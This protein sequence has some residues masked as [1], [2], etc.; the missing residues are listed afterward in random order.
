MNKELK[1]KISV[2]KKTG[3]VKVI[4]GEFDKL[5]NKAGKA[6]RKV[7][8]FNK[9]LNEVDGDLKSLA[10]MAGSFYVISQAISGAT[11]LMS[12]YLESADKMTTLN[13]KLRLVTSSSQELQETQEKLF[14]IAQNT[15]TSLFSNVDL[16]Q[17]I[18]ASTRELN[19]SQKERLGLVENINKAMVI[20]G[21][22]TAGVNT[23][24][25]QLG[26]AF[27]SDFKSVAQDLRSVKDQAFEL[28]E[29]FLRGTKMNA[30]EFRKAAQDGELSTK[31]MIDAI[32]SQ[33]T[34]VDTNFLK[35]ALTVD[36]ASQT[37][38]NSTY[39]LIENMDKITGIS[40]SL[41]SSI[42]GFRKSLD[43]L[44]ED[45]I[46]GYADLAGTIGLVGTSLL[47]A[48]VA[49]KAYSTLLSIVASITARNTT[50]LA[51]R[52]AI[53]TA[54][55]K[56]MQLG[57]YAQNARTLADNASTLAIKNNSVV[58]SIRAGVL[59]EEA[60]VAT[61]AALAQT[62][63]ARA[64]DASTGAASR[65]TIV[66]RGLSLVLKS[67]PFIG[68]AS[69]VFMLTNYL[70]DASSASEDLAASLDKTGKKL[71]EMSKN[72]LEH[73]RTVI[74]SSLAD[75]VATI[76]ETKMDA[77]YKSWHETAEEHA[78]DQVRKDEALAKLKEMGLRYKNI[79]QMIKDIANIQESSSAQAKPK[80]IDKDQLSLTQQLNAAI[81]KSNPY[82]DLSYKFEAY[83]LKAK[84]NIKNL[85][86]I[87]QWYAMNFKKLKD[88]ELEVHKRDLL[89]KEKASLDV[90]TTSI[91]SW[92]EYYEN[93][94]DY[95]TSWLIQES[96]FKTK[97][98]DLTDEQFTQA[99]LKA[100]EKYFD[101]IGKEELTLKLNGVDEAYDGMNTILDSQLALVEST[102]SW[103]SNLSGVAGAFVDIS[104]SASKFR[105]DEINSTKNQNNLDQK[106]AKDYL[107]LE[108]K[109]GDLK[110]LEKQYDID[111]ARLKSD[112]FNN[113]IQGYSNIA[114]A[115]GSMYEEG[116]KGAEIANMAQGI[117]A[118]TQGA[119]AI[120]T[121]GTG[122]PYTAI[123][124]MIAMAATV[125][126]VLGNA[127]IS[128][129]EGIS[130]GA[131]A[132]AQVQQE[133]DTLEMSYEPMTNRLD[134]QIE[135]LESIDRN[136]SAAAL[137]VELAEVEF[138]QAYEK[139]K[140]ETFQKARL[141]ALDSYI[142]KDGEKD[143]S[144][145]EERI[146]VD[147]FTFG[148]TD[149]QQT[150][151]INTEILKEK[152]NLAIALSDIL[153]TGRYSGGFEQGIYKDVGFGKEAHTAFRLNIDKSFSDLQGYVNDW[154][155]STIDSVNQLSDASSTLKD[156][157]DLIG[158]GDFSYQDERLKE[159]FIDLD[160]LSDKKGYAQYIK[161]EIE[162]IEIAKNYLDD[163]KLSLLLSKDTK[164]FVAQLEVVTEFSKI[165]G[166]AFTD[167]AK[168]VINYIE[169]IE[170]V[171]QAMATSEKN[172][173]SW[174]DSFKTENEITQDLFKQSREKMATDY[175]ELQNL[176]MKLSSD[177]QG[178]DDNELNFLNANKSFLDKEKAQKE[179]AQK[180]AMDAQKKAQKEA[181]DAHKKAQ[182]EK[183]DA[184]KKAYNAQIKD[185][186]AQQ[187]ALSQ[188]LSNTSNSISTIESAMD[189]LTGVI[190][191]LS[192][193]TKGSSYHIDN[194]FSSMQE[195]LS[196]SRTK[197]RKSFAESLSKTI[198]YSS[199]LFKDSNFKSAYASEFERESALNEFN[200]M[201]LALDTELSV[202][203]QIEVNTKASAA[204]LKLQISGLNKS[205]SDLAKETSKPT[206]AYVAP[207]PTPAYVAPALIGDTSEK[208]IRN[209]YKKYS[210]MQYQTS[211]A[212]INSWAKDLESGRFTKKNIE[213]KIVN[214]ANSWFKD[215]GYS[216]RLKLDGSHRNG[217]NHVP[218]D[219]YIAELHKGEAVLT[220]NENALQQHNNPNKE[221]IATII[222]L[223]Q[224]IKTLTQINEEIRVYTMRSSS[225][226]ENA[227]NGRKP[228]ITKQKETF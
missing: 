79:T 65:A 137:N 98:V 19:L 22:T 13:S 196:L 211:D 11:S 70:F 157:F 47:G 117:L 111:S 56:A 135:L 127:G 81:A 202:L 102:N 186:N 58:G 126:Q 29:V 2:D 153:Q 131:S 224:E 42:D 154:A 123:P 17:K 189:S 64:L 146:E 92:K 173:K 166:K 12:K 145:W 179:K 75:A 212:G 49:Y 30:A 53:T 195:T 138:S 27:G 110:G 222:E 183:T 21:T 45:E 97:F 168:G 3:A 197:D 39:R 160:N 66:S 125:S 187:S 82:D 116:S 104:K 185:L 55:T 175:E 33:T 155:L 95:G 149:Q 144:D 217:L 63:H 180:E 96:Q 152:N 198:G 6:G 213:I 71:S 159:A 225:A 162:T 40:A 62:A 221:L 106:Y 139:W 24:V 16:Y 203:Q 174:L 181:M 105:V 206:P 20:S 37:M 52:T 220:A 54:D 129:G 190:D 178:L 193:V 68:I 228:L 43:S 9:R 93:I 87:D 41:S 91:D 99:S 38:S 10:K 208:I 101:A 148:G 80:K 136:G 209:L 204:A 61:T 84:G 226:L 14:D 26:Q 121:A 194:Y 59:R 140:L 25:T 103:G 76:Q 90:N 35:M 100:K 50:Q 32:E 151:S 113:Q 143:V 171:T 216:R 219:G 169:S 36:G 192:G 74:E 165:T 201:D 72:E 172:K 133:L 23:L 108:A 134:Q 44:D 142:G 124:R 8:S 200:K 205:I 214:G 5:S 177:K 158:D 73:K 107:K 182:K 67:L 199:E 161:G 1:I 122:D 4:G 130:A 34:A 147:V 88:G 164:N 132:Q 119:V 227:V 46:K 188:S 31:M 141:G 109:K 112:N 7:D 115:I 85:A 57:A 223:R 48:T 150:V 184:Q 77:K 118:I 78:K 207:K 215:N 156:S 167:G 191:N 218:Y 28:Y 94:G 163:K 60:K 210:L 86:L 15:A 69:G 128:G 89:A 170:L 18:S 51:L 83:V 176:Y 114:G 120:V